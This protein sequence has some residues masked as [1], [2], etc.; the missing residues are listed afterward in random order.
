MAGSGDSGAENPK[1]IIFII[2]IT[3]N[4]DANLKN[5]LNSIKKVLLIRTIEL[6]LV[7]LEGMK[8]IAGLDE[9]GQKV[10]GLNT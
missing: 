1:R 4:L 6:R 8:V 5:F 9:Q 3:T 10:E 7:I 2:K